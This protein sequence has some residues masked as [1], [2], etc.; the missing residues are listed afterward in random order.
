M[1]SRDLYVKIRLW[2]TV[3]AVNLLGVRNYNKKMIRK[4]R[5]KFKRK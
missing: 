2:G 1:T 3:R 5:Q 4:V